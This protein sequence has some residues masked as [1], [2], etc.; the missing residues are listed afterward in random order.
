[1]MQLGCDGGRQRL[2]SPV[3]PTNLIQSFCNFSVRRVWHLL[4]NF[5]WS[6]YRSQNSLA[7]SLSQSGDPVKRARAIVQAVSPE[8]IFVSFIDY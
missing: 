8:S 7:H 3:M 4:G 5:F 6:L 2:L 1:M